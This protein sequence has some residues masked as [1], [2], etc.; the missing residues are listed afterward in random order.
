MEVID[1]T[2]APPKMVKTPRQRWAETTSS[3]GAG[4]LGAGIGSTFPGTLGRIGIPLILLGAA[5]HGWGMFDMR[6]MEAS[7]V[8]PAWSAVLYW[9]CWLLLAG[10]AVRLA[11]H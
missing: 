1:R 3:L 10:L 4:L 7:R 8:R 2:G 9:V 6:R 11:F 5:M